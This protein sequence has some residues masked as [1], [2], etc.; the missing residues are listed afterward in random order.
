MYEINLYRM[1][2]LIRETGKLMWKIEREQ[3]Y[4][5]KCSAPLSELNWGRGNRSRVEEGA[6]R[7]IE[8]KDAYREVLEELEKMRDELDPLISSLKNADDRAVMRLRY[9]K[10]YCPEDISDAVCLTERMVYYILRR[11][12]N[13]LARLYPEKI[14]PND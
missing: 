6:I 3:A 4:A 14:W 1:R 10:G 8:L 11:S 2:R 13:A 9:I 7:I 5:T 12:E